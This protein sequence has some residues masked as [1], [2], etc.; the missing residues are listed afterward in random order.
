[1]GNSDLAVLSAESRQN[2]MTSENEFPQQKVNLYI[3]SFTLHMEQSLFR[4]L[5]NQSCKNMTLCSVGKAW[6]TDL[7]VSKANQSGRFNSPK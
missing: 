5:N 1:M 2:Q 4:D 3:S 6:V 7:G